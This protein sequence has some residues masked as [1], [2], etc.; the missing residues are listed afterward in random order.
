MVPNQPIESHHGRSHEA[1]PG[2]NQSGLR[3][4]KTD[5]LY[6]R[7]SGCPLT[8]S[9]VHKKRLLSKFGGPLTYSGSVLLCYFK[10]CRAVQSS[11]FGTNPPVRSGFI[12]QCQTLAQQTGT[13]NKSLLKTCVVLLS[14]LHQKSSKESGLQ[15]FVPQRLPTAISN[16]VTPRVVVKSNRINSTPSPAQFSFSN[17]ASFLCK[18]MGCQHLA[19]K[20]SLQNT[21]HTYCV[22]DISFPVY[23]RTSVQVYK[24][25]REPESAE[26]GWLNQYSLIH[27]GFTRN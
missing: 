18:W 15:Q 7:L 13:A 21:S 10:R 3:K 11:C 16:R 24:R 26:V 4:K 27:Y 20:W 14:L 6:G 12:I 8:W 2:L 22:C 17:S 1:K 25:K 23:K 19:V 9:V 5:C